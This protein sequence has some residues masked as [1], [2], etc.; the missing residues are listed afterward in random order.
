M[1]STKDEDIEKLENHHDHEE[2]NEH[3]KM[4]RRNS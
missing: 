4:E 3:M 1:Q 2:D